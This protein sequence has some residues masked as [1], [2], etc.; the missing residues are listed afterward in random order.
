MVIT[1]TSQDR[2]KIARLCDSTSKVIK[3]K[4]R[5]DKDQ[6]TRSL[7]NLAKCRAMREALGL[8]FVCLFV[9]QSV[10]PLEPTNLI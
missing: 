1:P 7:F 3:V 2:K 8:S 4:T 10:D 6:V 9:C 5:F